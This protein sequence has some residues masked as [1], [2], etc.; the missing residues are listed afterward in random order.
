MTTEQAGVVLVVD[1]EAGVRELISRWLRGLGYDV[2]TAS[3]A[4][5][6]LRL[7]A[8]RTVAVALCDIRM[9]GRDGLWL[10]ERLRD[11]H[12]DIAIVMATGMQDVASAM[13]SLRRNATD[14]LMKPFG[15]DRLREAVERAM[16]WHR[17]AAHG[18]ESGARRF[19]EMRQ[20]RDQLAQALGAL[21]GQWLG[22]LEAALAI[23]SFYEAATAAHVRRVADGAG[24]VAR[25]MGR[26]PAELDLLEC[27]ALVHEF[28][29]LALPDDV[30]PEQGPLKPSEGALVREAPAIGYELL[31]ALPGLA[32]AARVVH[33]RHEQWDGGGYPRGIRGEA[34]P[35]PSRILAVVDSYDTMV[36]LPG[37][38][39]AS[40]VH[41]AL[42]ELRRCSGR[43]FDPEVVRTFERV[44]AERASSPSR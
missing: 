35:L 32:E 19:L 40:S 11:A 1:D 12:P 23:V 2:I 26:P 36:G 38:L 14:Y 39:P 29:Q 5:E 15:R 3:D 28:E 43:D 37:F 9:P 17:A 34:I 25:A 27:A 30:L 42:S 24:A 18:R 7:S 20:R 22:S 44:I 4:E 16:A 10:A 8:G 6:A 41:D 33:A 31:G 21:A 13:A